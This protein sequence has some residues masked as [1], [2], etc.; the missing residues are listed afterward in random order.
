[1]YVSHISDKLLIK[2]LCNIN[3]I[4]CACKF[5]PIKTY[6]SCTSNICYRSIQPD[7][8]AKISLSFPLIP[9]KL[10]QPNLNCSHD[11]FPILE[12]ILHP[13][14]PLWTHLLYSCTMLSNTLESIPV[15]LSLCIAS[16]S[17]F[18]IGSLFTSSLY[19]FSL[20]KPDLF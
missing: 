19:P 4:R 1:M 7:Q 9:Y 13:K 14:L 8:I 10:L 3:C 5:A 18:C 2:F 6:S 15:F 20:Q 17:V 12:H 11:V 16:G